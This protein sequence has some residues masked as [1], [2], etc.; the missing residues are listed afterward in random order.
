MT[1]DEMKKKLKEMGLDF[2]G[3]AGQWRQKKEGIH[4]GKFETVQNLVQVA[5]QMKLLLEKQVAQDQ[6]TLE[7]LHERLKRVQ[8]GGGQ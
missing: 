5:E 8:H 7:A 3:Q 1:P 6:A 4:V 2:E